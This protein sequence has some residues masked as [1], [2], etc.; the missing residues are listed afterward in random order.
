MQAIGFH[1]A[2]G[3]SDLRVENTWPRP[4]AGDN[5]CIVQVKCFGLNYADIVAR[6]GNYKDAPPFPFIPGYEVSGTVVEIGARNDQTLLATADGDLAVGDRVVAFTAF[7]GYAEFVCCKLGMSTAPWLPLM[8]RN[9]TDINASHVV[10]PLIQ[11]P[12]CA[13][14]QA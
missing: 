11:R 9:A 8:L 5:E 10:S 1:K 14:H 3:A 12:C 6:T 7:G 4:T 2:C 13:F